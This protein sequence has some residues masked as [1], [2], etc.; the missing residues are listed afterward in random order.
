MWQVLVLSATTAPIDGKGISWDTGS[1]PDHYVEV[2]VGG[3][4]ES[5]SVINNSPIP[6]WDE[7][8]FDNLSTQALT[9][10]IAFEIWDADTFPNPDDSMG[11]CAF[12]LDTD[13]FG[14]Q[15]AAE[16]TGKNRNV[17]WTLQLVLQAVAE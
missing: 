2:T 14:V 3:V 16:C 11:A 6:V 12:G 4:L 10:G 15:V 1:F 13:D 17:L 9:E 7:L 5:T 8:L